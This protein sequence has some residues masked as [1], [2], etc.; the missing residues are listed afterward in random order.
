MGSGA[1]VVSPP[2]FTLAKAATPE[3]PARAVGA[4][5][6]GRPPPPASPQPSTPPAAEEAPSPLPVTP[7]RAL[8]AEAEPQTPVSTP[9]PSEAAADE[10][11]ALAAPLPPPPPPPQE[12]AR[13]QAAQAPPPPVQSRDCVVGPLLATG[14][15]FQ[16]STLRCERRARTCVACG[17]SSCTCA[18]LPAARPSCGRASLHPLRCRHKAPTQTDAAPT[19]L[20]LTR[21]LRVPPQHGVEVVWVHTARAAQGA[22]CAPHPFCRS[23]A[24]FYRPPANAALACALSPSSNPR[25]AALRMPPCCDARHMRAHAAARA[26]VRSCG[27]FLPICRGATGGAVVAL[28][29]PHALPPP[30][31]HRT[32]GEPDD[33]LGTLARLLANKAHASHHRVVGFW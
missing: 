10:E 8:A 21:A 25:C 26:A 2:S 24:L 27:G 14:E 12:E 20:A 13:V 23:C 29:H 17:G 22:W 16:V 5:A 3:K 4:A 11:E 1:A 18:R 31:L 15:L 32:A 7:V 33:D 28:F 30:A 6:F 19:A 9:P